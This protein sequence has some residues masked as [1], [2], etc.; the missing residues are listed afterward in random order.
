[1]PERLAPRLTKAG[2]LDLT[3]SNLFVRDVELHARIVEHA[4]SIEGMH[5]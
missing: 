2:N 5:I 1:M 3:A 4:R